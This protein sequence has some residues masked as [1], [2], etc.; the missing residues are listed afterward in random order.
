MDPDKLSQFDADHL[1]KV[2][3][4]RPEVGTLTGHRG[5]EDRLP[6]PS[7]EGRAAGIDALVAWRDARQSDEARQGQPPREFELDQRVF[8]A[9][10]ELARWVDQE[11]APHVR[12]PDALSPLLEVLAIQRTSPV[13]ETAR[14]EA[15]GKRL[16]A[17]PEYLEKSRAAVTEPDALLVE[18]ADETL[19]AAGAFAAD[20]AK[21]AER[22]ARKER[23]PAS[24]A[25]DVSAAAEKARAALEE[26]R[27][28]LEGLSPEENRFVLGPERLDDLLHRRGLDI[29]TDEM[30]ELGRSMIEE[31][32]IEE[33]RL[34]RRAFRK[35][36]TEEAL[37]LARAQQPLSFDEVLAWTAELIEQ[38]RAFCADSDI[39]AVPEHANLRLAAAPAGF[40]PTHADALLVP[41]SPL[42]GDEPAR[43]LLAAPE[44]GDLTR[45]SVADLESLTARY[46]FPGSHL[47]HAWART[48]TGMLRAGAP[49]GTLVPLASTW[50]AEAAAGWGHHCEETMRELTFRDSPAAR[51]VAIRRALYRAV[52]ARV[53]VGLAVGEYTVE[54]AIERL[55]AHG[56]VSEERARRDVRACARRPMHAISPLIGKMR[57][58]QLRREAKAIWRHGFSERRFNELVLFGGPI[59]LTYLFELLE[60]PPLYALD[61]GTVEYQ[62]GDDDPDAITEGESDPE[63]GDDGADAAD[64]GGDETAAE[65]AV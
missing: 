13:D 62:L 11:L 24:L 36:P 7:P 53:D 3:E 35:L 14:T 47:F 57:L 22:A 30:R 33:R 2:V 6:D 42:G 27:A 19:T 45:F 20:V 48:A 10:L 31:M 17:L 65:E 54:N 64:A 16:A 56:G 15:L 55:V 46:G 60:M 32:R 8:S 52:L 21:S 37:E 59:P 39:Y 50:G 1:E 61:E 26:Q 63:A 51:M 44:S 49:L 12:D 5:A 43:L 38:A 34:A 4:V 28:W 29:T 25:E 40:K 58:Q 18:A 9:S 23:I 41:A